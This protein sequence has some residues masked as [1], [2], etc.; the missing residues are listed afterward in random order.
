MPGYLKRVTYFGNN[1]VTR[2]LGSI[3]AGGNGAT[4]LSL[5]SSHNAVQFSVTS[6]TSAIKDLDKLMSIMDEE[7]STL[8]LAYDYAVEGDD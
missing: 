1:P 5:I 2:I 3:T 8:N 6:D 7:I 4:S